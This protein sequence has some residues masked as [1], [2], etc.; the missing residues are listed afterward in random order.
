MIFW[1]S[2]FR[3]GSALLQKKELSEFHKIPF[4]SDITIKFYMLIPIKQS[5]A[6]FEHIA[7]SYGKNKHKK[8]F[9][10]KF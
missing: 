8:K 3:V 4:K 9:S 7:Q 6:D 2:I 10:T 1:Y 5:P